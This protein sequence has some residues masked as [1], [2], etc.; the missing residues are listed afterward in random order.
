MTPT[1]VASGPLPG[2]L[3]SPEN[4]GSNQAL[5]LRARAGKPTTDQQ[6]VDAH[7]APF[8][9]NGLT[10]EPDSATHGNIAPAR[11]VPFVTCEADIA[12]TRSDWQEDES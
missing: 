10:L 8:F 5:G 4:T 9:A 12:A 2:A 1:P 7:T 11:V 3:A 6:L